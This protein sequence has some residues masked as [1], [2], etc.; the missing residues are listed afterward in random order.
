VSQLI[1]LVHA[2]VV[3]PSSWRPVAD[4]LR[5]AGR[6]VAVP[7]LAGFAADGPPYSRRLIDLAAGQVLAD[8]Q[9]PV[10]LVTHSGAGVFA[11]QL[12][13]AIGAADTTMIFADASLP[14]SSG[15]GP[16][17]DGQF[18]PYLR[19][20]AADGLVPPWPQW[21]PEEDLS[22][23]FPDDQTRRGVLAEA[24]SLPLAFFE[25]TLPPMPGAWPPHRAGYLLFSAGYRQ[26]AC[27]A[28]S[29]GW[30]V[31][32]IAGEHLHMLVSPA[33]VAAAIIALA[34]QPGR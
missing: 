22:P 4:E 32:E 12:G 9:D 16:V 20:I 7:S 34:G 28:G 27:A 11:A 13:A 25:E 23:L 30:P 31:T 14:G 26:Q 18:L 19:E 21:W 10:V 1:V 17:V 3:G 6:D 33:Q 24:A 29:L 8:P 5:R 2:P 15:G